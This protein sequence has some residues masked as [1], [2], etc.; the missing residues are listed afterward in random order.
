MSEKFWDYFSTRSLVLYYQLQRHLQHH[1]FLITLS[2]LGDELKLQQLKQ[3]N[4]DYIHAFRTCT[5]DPA[6][7]IDTFVKH[8][9]VCR[10][11]YANEHP[12]KYRMDSY[13][14]DILREV[15]NYHLEKDSYKPRQ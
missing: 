14:R 8:M 15:T 11:V 1:G 12:A 10:L 3:S 2:M 7:P 6:L 4:R 13:V 5:V 9:L